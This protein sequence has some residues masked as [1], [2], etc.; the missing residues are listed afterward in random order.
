MS[1][2]HGG[3]GLSSPYTL[4]WYYL[5]QSGG[6]SGCLIC[7]TCKVLDSY[8]LPKKLN[9]RGEGYMDVSALPPGQ[10]LART[11]WGT[12]ESGA[13]FDRKKTSY[14]TEQDQAVRGR[15]VHPVY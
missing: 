7:Y 3:F 12:H 5:A 10:H 13:A 1:A 15:C 2:S 9:K 8:L 4:P 14:L 6:E 11:Y